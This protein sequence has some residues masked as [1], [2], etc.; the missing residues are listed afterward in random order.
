[1]PGVVL[2]GRYPRMIPKYNTRGESLVYF[3]LDI[4]FTIR[5]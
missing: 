5:E 4:F 3:V 2:K 1:M